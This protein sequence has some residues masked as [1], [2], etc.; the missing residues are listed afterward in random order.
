MARDESESAAMILRSVLWLGR[1]LRAARPRSGVSLAGI[2]VLSTLR[3]LGP[4]PATRLATEERLQP[5]SLTRIIA[6]L[7]R[8]R[9]IIRTRN[10]HDRREILIALTPQGHRVLA[11]DLR[12]R[13]EW[14]ERAMAETLNPAERAAL[15]R[16][17][18]P[19]LKLARH[20]DAARANA[21]REPGAG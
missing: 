2:G 19:L 3:R 5:Q 12:G 11:D 9:C 10:P 17:A 16:A 7:V 6:Q 20:D 4:S 8:A 21:T 14:L 1:R 18:E 15:L 13:Q